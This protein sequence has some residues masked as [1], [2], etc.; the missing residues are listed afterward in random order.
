MACLW[1][2]DCHVSRLSIMFPQITVPLMHHGNKRMYM[3]DS[4]QPLTL[5]TVS[6]SCQYGL[7]GNYGA[8][9]DW[10]KERSGMTS[11]SG[12]LLIATV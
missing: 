12:K 7:Y 8:W 3:I 1:L 11:E 6:V 4:L 10:S 5:Y 9:S 2:G